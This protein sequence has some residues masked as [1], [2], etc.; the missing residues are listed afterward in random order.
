VTAEDAEMLKVLA[1]QGPVTMH[2]TLTPQTL[3]NAQSYNVI[4]DWKGT[5]HPEQV[6]VV[7]GHLDSWDLGTGAIDDGAGVAV[8]MQAI[9]LMKE[10][11]IHPRRTVRVIAWMSEEEGSEGAAAY[12]AEHAAEM[13]NHVGAIESDLGADHPTGIFY[14]GKPQL[15]QWLRPVAQVLDADG[16][17]SLVSAPETGED[18]AAMT[19]KGVPSFA[20][21]QDNRFYFDYHHTAADTFDKIDKKHLNEN[22]AVMAVL[23]YALADSAEAAAR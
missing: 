1:S 13:G 16:A 11:G 12:M 17:G 4:A 3:P 10:L 14:A 22:A 9:Q 15:G 2:L 20:P 7:S 6:V 8:S 18:I 19:A 21:V 23:A 5:E